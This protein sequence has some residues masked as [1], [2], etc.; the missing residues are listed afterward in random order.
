M[1]D[2]ELLD[3]G[4]KD[5]SFEEDGMFFREF[6]LIYKSICFE[7]DGDNSVDMSIDNNWTTVPNCETIEDLK[8]LVRLFI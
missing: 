2:K 1:S 7:I 4:F 3:L 8:Q 6:T 5:T